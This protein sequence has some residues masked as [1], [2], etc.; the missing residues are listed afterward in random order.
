MATLGAREVIR[1]RHEKSA[2]NP[3]VGIE[4]IPVNLIASPIT[5][6]PAST[7]GVP[8]PAFA[9]PIMREGFITNTG[10]VPTKYDLSVTTWRE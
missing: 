2:E 5:V 1:K 8:T 6:Q 7:L 4:S 10:L 3:S 9:T